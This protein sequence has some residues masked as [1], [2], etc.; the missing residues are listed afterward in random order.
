MTASSTTPIFLDK[1][2]PLS[3]KKLT[4]LIL[5]IGIKKSEKNLKIVI[6]TMFGHLLKKLK[7]S[8][9]SS[10]PGSFE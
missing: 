8:I 6:Y 5:Q 9:H 3:I 10:L 4:Q 1:L 2:Q 7:I